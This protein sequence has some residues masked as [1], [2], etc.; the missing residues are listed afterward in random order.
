[1]DGGVGFPG[2]GLKKLHTEVPNPAIITATSTATRALRLFDT[3]FT[4][5]TSPLARSRNDH[6]RNEG[7][8]G[9]DETTD[10]PA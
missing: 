3:R 2:R 6:D 5:V 1:M 9:D 8:D 10:T 7:H 4:V